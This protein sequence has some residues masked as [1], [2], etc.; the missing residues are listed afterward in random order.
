MSL[1]ADL[2]AIADGLPPEA[3]Q[4]MAGQIARLR[5]SGA[6]A[7]APKAGDTAPD[8]ILPDAHGNAV[9][10]RA[11]LMAGPAVLVFYPGPWC[12]YCNTELAAYQKALPEI[13][14]RRVRLVAISPELPD[15]SLTEDEMDRLDFEILSDAGNRVARQFGLVYAL[16]GE[17]RTLLEGHGVDLAR[18]H[19]DEA[20]ELPVPTV[21]V[22]ARDRRIAFAS[23]DADFR[24]RP[25]PADVVAAL[26]TLGRPQ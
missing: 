21:Y 4:A 13:A 26:D 7:A 16:D 15:Q 22:I 12:P 17:A 6:G 23:A 10:L 2:A 25:D 3:A 11:I 24:Y 19:G 5:A 14:A 20:W 9:A 8:F 18:L 1:Q